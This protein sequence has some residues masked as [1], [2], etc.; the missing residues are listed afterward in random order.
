M[1]YDGFPSFFFV[2][3]FQLTSFRVLPSFAECSYLMERS[4]THLRGFLLVL[5]S[6]FVTEFL[7]AMKGTLFSN[8]LEKKHLIGLCYIKWARFDRIFLLT[9]LWGFSTVLPSFTEFLMAKKDSLIPNVLANRVHLVLPSI[10]IWWKEKSRRWGFLLVLPS[11]FFVTEFPI[12]C[13]ARVDAGRGARFRLA[14]SVARSASWRFYGFSFLCQRIRRDRSSISTASFSFYFSR[15]L[16]GR[17]FFFFFIFP[18][19]E[20][21]WNDAYIY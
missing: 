10:W 20:P 12:V 18:R 21:E 2:C 9:R 5:P 3:F 8:L 14:S 15:C 19:L 11:F 16:N 1:P 13:C 6:F 17:L 4:K 7:I